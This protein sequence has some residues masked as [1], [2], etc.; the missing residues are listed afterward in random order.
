M[1][2]RPTLA[3]IRTRHPHQFTFADGAV[4]CL[5][6]PGTCDVAILLRTIEKQEKVIDA[7][8]EVENM[9]FYVGSY[10]S[11]MLKLFYRK[12]AALEGALAALEG[13]H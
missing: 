10:D 6:C 4:G 1:P 5:N 3:E 7:A 2:T 11:E 13:K 9:G 8:R 12:V